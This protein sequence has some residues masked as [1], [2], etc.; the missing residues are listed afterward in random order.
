MKVYLCGPIRDCTDDECITWRKQARKTL[1]DVIDPMARD[2]RGQ[3]E[4]KEVTKEI[5]ELD[6]MDIDNSEALLVNY[7]KPSTGTAMEIL[8]AWERNKPIIVVAPKKE[9]KNN[10]WLKYHSTHI[11][12]TFKEAFRLLK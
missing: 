5:V 3:E 8:Y 11:V 4:E 10:P 1:G 2:Y 12:E 9:V 7:F 6:K